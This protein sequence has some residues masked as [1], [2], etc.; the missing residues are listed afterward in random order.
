MNLEEYIDYPEEKKT[1]E[2]LSDHEIGNLAINSEP[3][4]DISDKDDDSTEM[5]QVTHNEAL[6]ATY[7]L[8]Q[9]LL[10]Q[11]LCNTAQLKYD[12]A[13]SNLQKMIRKLQNTSF[14]QLDFEA[15]FELVD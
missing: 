11:D 7:L 3:K 8:E 9:Y 6:N 5:H 4:E 13:L 12:K 15:F 14:K 1:Y 2:V 10:Q